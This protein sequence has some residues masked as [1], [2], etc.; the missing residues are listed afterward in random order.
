M[1]AVQFT[2]CWIDNEDDQ[3]DFLVQ[4][5][6]E[7]G[8]TVKLDRWTLRA[9]LSLWDQIRTHILGETESDAWVWYATQKQPSE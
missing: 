5:L 3:A 6:Q 1:A 7:T 2:Y 4:Q 9:G 8:L